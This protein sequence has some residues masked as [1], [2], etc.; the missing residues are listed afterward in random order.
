MSGKEALDFSFA[1]LYLR[2]YKSN[3]GFSKI[4]NT[5]ASTVIFLISFLTIS[6]GI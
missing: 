5:I 4:V 1:F 6:S 3:A 2:F